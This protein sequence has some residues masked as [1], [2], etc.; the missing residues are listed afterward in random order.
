VSDGFAKAE[1][2]SNWFL[3]LTGKFSAAIGQLDRYTD[4]HLAFLSAGYECPRCKK[5]LMKWYGVANAVCYGA[6]GAEVPTILIR[7]KGKRFACPKC[8]YTWDFRKATEPTAN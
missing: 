7:S 4:E 3:K 8:Q 2:M 6:D 1:I 5:T